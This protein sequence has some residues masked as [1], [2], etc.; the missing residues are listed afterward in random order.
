M[1]VH[2][3][4]CWAWSFDAIASGEKTADLRKN[5]R[6]Y[7]VGDIL[8][9]NRTPSDCMAPGTYFP[10]EPVKKMFVLVK[11]VFS[12][13]EVLGAAGDGYVVMS[14]SRDGVMDAFASESERLINESLE[15]E[16]KGEKP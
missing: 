4:K 1:K 12:A 3:L 2:D 9:L 16:N 6:D 15:K 14:V 11:H 8:R 7:H 10:P 5:D 13:S